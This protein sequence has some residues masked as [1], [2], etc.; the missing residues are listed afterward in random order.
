V[1]DHAG[2]EAAARIRPGGRELTRS[3]AWATFALPLRP[4]LGL[5]MKCPRCQQ[6]NPPKAKFCLECGAPLGGAVATDRSYAEL[7][8][9]NEGLRRSL[10]EASEQQTA[11]A[12]IL[13][14][15]SNSPT[16][17]LPVLGAMA[18]R[19]ARLCAAYDAILLRL[20]GEVLRR[21]A[22]YG[23]IAPPPALVF[24]ATRDTVGGRTVL[25]RRPIHVT[26]LQAETKEFPVGS[27]AA[28]QLGSRTVLGVPLLRQGAAIGV[29]YIRRT[30]VQPFTEAQIAL[31]QTFAD[32]AVIAIENVRLF[33]ETKEAL[34]QQ[35]ATAEILRVISASPTDVQPVLNAV[36]DC[37][38]RICGAQDVMILRI[39]G[40]SLRRVAHFGAIPLILPAVRPLT[41]E[42]MAGRAALEGRVIHVP[43]M[44][45]AVEEYPESAPQYRGAGL[46]TGAAVPL[47]RDGAA[48]GV[49]GIRRTEVRPFTD[50]QIA[51]LQ[52]FAE[53]AVIAI[54]NVRLFTELREKNKALSQAHAN[55]RSNRC[56]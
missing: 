40:E 15:I 53:Q 41:R 54:E 44:L 48:I 5:R 4:A 19:A 26:D 49:I 12:E 21:V 8:A 11:T 28:R 36:A 37:A 6:E 3:G 38:A 42:S 17:L 23:P 27:A 50:T 46:R 45:E 31:L 7:Q 43:N 20:D 33:N 1:I 29:I 14:V 52:T 24:P 2:A 22:H 51:L 34:E 47:L 16:D 55:G 32:Q 35:T 25:D 10:G 13:R 56:C 30:E 9:E 18:E 39:E